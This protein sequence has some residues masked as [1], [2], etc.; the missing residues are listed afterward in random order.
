VLRIQQDPVLDERRR[1]LRAWQER[2]RDPSLTVLLVL[3]QC[4]IFLAEPLAAR[5]LPIARAVADI[6]VLALVL[7]VVV[8]QTGRH[9][10]YFARL[11]GNGGGLPLR[12]GVVSGNGGRGPARRKH[13]CLFGTDLGGSACSLCPGPYHVAAFK[14]RSLCISI[15][16]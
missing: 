8:A 7:I 4:T 12:A 2:V 15:S 16:R 5:G 10:F 14:A 3:E 1:R 13:P 6:L 9:S 11:G